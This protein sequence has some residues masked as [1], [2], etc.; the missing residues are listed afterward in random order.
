MNSSLLQLNR[1]DWLIGVLIVLLAFALRVWVVI[2]RANGDTAFAPIPAGA[3]Q[4]RYFSDAQEFFRG[5]WPRGAFDLHPGSTY[6]L[7]PV[8]AV[9]GDSLVTTRLAMALVGA[10]SC[11]ALVAAGWLLTQRRWGGYLAGLLMAVY[12]VAIFASTDFLSELGAVLWVSLF[13]WLTFWQ[14]ERLFWLRSLL[15]GVLIGLATLHRL[16]LILLAPAWL[17]YLYL[18][19]SSWRARLSHTALLAVGLI[20]SIGPVTAWNIQHDAPALVTSRHGFREIYY[21]NNRDANGLWEGRMAVFARDVPHE[22]ALWNDIRRDPLRFIEL[23]LRKTGIYWNAHEPGNN[24]NFVVNGT[25]VSPLLRAIPLDFRILS[26]LGLLGLVPLYRSNRKAAIFLIALQIVLFAGTVAII[27]EGR[28][29]WPTIPA[30]VMSA[31]ALLLAWGD[32][33]RSRQWAQIAR[34]YALPAVLVGLLLIGSEWAYQT[35]PVKRPYAS[36]PGDV[37]GMGVVFDDTLE[38]VGWRPLPGQESVSDRGWGDWNSAYVVELFWRVQQPTSVNYQF[39]LRGALN[40]EDIGGVDGTIGTVSFQPKPTSQWQPGEI[41]GEI[42]GFRLP[43]D[44]PSAQNIAI[45]ASAYRIGAAGEV[46]RVSASTD[47]LVV[48]QTIAAYD[49]NEQPERDGL[50]PADLD[51]GGLIALK[52]LVLP[53]EVAPNSPQTI[54]FYWE[55]QQN[56]PRDYSLFVHVMSETDN[57]VASYDGPPLRTLNTSAWKPG[58]AVYG[59]VPLTMPA[60]P[61]RYEVYIGLYD[62]QERLPVDAPDSRP[63]IGTLVVQ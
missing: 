3:D 43:V 37:H 60:Q 26:A 56:V 20:L 27:V 2:D 52:G 45:L 41:Y 15:I 19:A 18:L 6:L 11:G 40:D 58:Y 54:S 34:Q 9:L 14:Q 17:V 55:A 39:A 33:I 32:L 63:F 30:L 59:D 51:F 7:I 28:M 13:L 22:V 62:S 5:R 47:G 29:R 38:L 8:M 42:V 36:L 4:S 16:S 49:P 31:S 53:D 25:A 23:Q 46:V 10:L 1:R 61:G 48:V 57:L 44:T 21:G 24:L 12:P 50:T 35:L